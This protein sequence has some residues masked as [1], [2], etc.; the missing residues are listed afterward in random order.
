[1]SPSG[2]IEL[3]CTRKQLVDLALTRREEL[4]EIPAAALATRFGEDD[5]ERIL[6]RKLVPVTTQP[7]NVNG[8]IM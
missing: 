3:L 7:P 2:P 6:L 4:V 1:M 5:E 8:S